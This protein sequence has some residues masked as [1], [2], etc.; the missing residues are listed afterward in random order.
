MITLQDYIGNEI[1]GETLNAIVYRGH[2]RSSDQRVIIK[3][4]KLTHPS[5]AQA[6]R[7]KHEYEIIR[8]VELEGVIKVLDIISTE[9]QLALVMADFGGV[10]LE[11]YF[12]NAMQ[13]APFLD[14][15]I[16]LAQILRS[17]HQKKI[18][19]RDI[20]PANILYNPESDELKLTDFGIAA[21]ASLG[22]EPAV[23]ARLMEGTLAYIS[24]E[25][26]GRMNCTVDYRTDFYSLGVT[27]YELLTGAPPFSSKDPMA[28]IHA[29][30]AKKPEPLHLINPRVPVALSDIIL[31]LMAKSADERYQSGLGL[32]ADLEQCREQLAVQARIDP[33]ELG[34][35]DI[36]PQFNAPRLLVGRAKELNDLYDAFEYVALGGT[37]VLMVSGEPGIGKSSLVNELH[38]TVVAKRGFFLTGKYEQLKQSTPYSGIIQALQGL[39]RQLLAE[40]QERIDLYK[41]DLISILGPN[42]KIITDIIPDMEA[43]L[44]MQPGIAELEPEAAQNRFKRVLRGFV[45][46]FADQG[47][48]LVMFLDDL[49]W[50]DPASPELIQT[51]VFDPE[52]KSFLLIGAYRDNEVSA[53]HPLMFALENIRDHGIASKSIT[54]G[55]LNKTSVNKMLANF[56]RCDPAVSQALATVFQQK[57]LGNPF[58][59]IQFL[60]RLFEGDHLRL[61]PAVGW[62]WE[63]GEVEKMQVTDNV[64]QFMAEK[65]VH[66]PTDAL[67]QIKIGAC[68]GNQFKLETLAAVTEA[69]MDR[70]IET[71]DILVD[72]GLITYNDGVCRFLHDRIQEAAYSLIP[73][74]EREQLHYR[75]GRLA[76]NQTAG[77]IHLYNVFYIAD[78]LN[79]AINILETRQERIQLADINL[80]AG[81]KAKAST[82]Y[83]AATKYLQS[84]IDLL[85]DNAWQSDYELT[86]GL[87]TA[88]MACQYLARNFDESEK[89][90][91]II[92]A[93]ARDRLDK[94]EA[95]NTMI[96]LYTN[97]RPPEEAVALSCSALK[98]FNINLD[99]KMG[100]AKVLPE[101]IKARLKIRKFSMEDIF[102]LPMA[103]DKERSAYHKILFNAGT[104][105]YF[106]NPN[107]F[108][109]IVLK[110]VNEALKYG[111]F[112]HAAVTF[113]T[114]ATLIENILGDYSLGYEMGRMALKLNQ[115]VNNQELSGMVHHIFAFLIQHWNR[116][117]KY[118]LP[119][120]R[121]V[122]QLCLDHGNF[123]Y[124]G[125]S[126]NATADCRLIIGESLESI[127]KDNIRYKGVI[128]Q[129]NDPFIIGRYEENNA[130]IQALKG[131][132]EDPTSLSGPN[133]DAEAHMERQREE[134]NIYGLCFALYHKIKLLYLFGRY[135]Q[136]LETARELERHIKAPLGTLIIS[137]HYYY[138]GLIL[139]ALLHQP[140]TTRR[141]K[142]KRMINRNINKLAKWSALCPENFGHKHDL[143]KAELAAVEG[144]IHQALKYYHGAINGARQNDYVNDEALA[145]ERL[146]CFYLGLSA[147]DEAR[148]FMHRAHQCYGY[149]GATA[150]QQDIKKNHEM[151]LPP[152][153]MG[154]FVDT[155]SQNEGSPT[156]SRQLDLAMVMEA[157]QTISSEIV[158]DQLLQKI[159]KISVTN[160]GAQ[161]GF[162]LLERN[163][164]LIIVAAEETD[165][166]AAPVTVPVPLTESKGLAHAIVYFVNRTLEPVILHNA[167]S[168]GLFTQNPYIQRNLCKSVLCMPILN[169]GQISGLLYMENNLTAN[170]FTDERLEILGVIAAQAA[171]S[172]ENARLFSLATTDG[173]TGLYVHRYFQLLLE[174]E[175][176]R[177]RRYERPF[178]LV[179]MD[180]DN[181]KLFND[182]YGHQQGDEVLKKVA[183]E[184]QD[185]I[186]TV[187]IAARYGGEEFV[188][189]LPE[190]DLTQALVLCEKIRVT[191]EKIPIQ[192]GEK[193]L[194]I[195]ISIG[196][197]TF[198]QHA[199]NKDTL[200][201][202]ADAALYASK[203]NGKNCVSVGKKINA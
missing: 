37:Q 50:C 194:N 193:T 104:P 47:H 136:A 66:L 96:V 80:K 55:P 179:M 132:T 137:E 15:A 149:W 67:S 172:M 3:L 6:A 2:H 191:I 150:K 121:K 176:N 41:Q 65:L 177:S 187:D 1:I 92:T 34:Q 124:A 25:Q 20:K 105:A 40:N 13:I 22:D 154:L 182:T 101:L 75:I 146:A 27:F 164:E 107:L 78:Q 57:T 17:L 63:A 120:Y 180:I 186:R 117:A 51:L 62:Q 71:I 126:V 134:N 140:E 44:G 48:P 199:V 84:G 46:I 175:I 106:L 108:A 100:P 68:I 116:H 9:D 102:E 144:R 188:L 35:H 61:D 59:V 110:G 72:D 99:M 197:A 165:K 109:S 200:I 135:A 142:Y 138:Q 174:K 18:V 181:F 81:I 36:S 76:L 118:D 49:Q 169:K 115:K 30:I 195:T 42:G 56:L 147:R 202:S 93:Q 21:D 123:L 127:L 183:R 45:R 192:P 10:S 24:P 189:V 8:K 5:P 156:I 54:L 173:L 97:T 16:R 143:V 133:F 152:K 170:A 155:V 12:P 196:V 58:F 148:I 103:R 112:P 178:S 198:P 88:Q 113:I 70:M 119:I 131:L 111:L 129:V 125:H 141:G 94:A 167:F 60:K 7:F 4:M 171:I 98:L 184:L 185:S 85:P 23:N 90:F 28:L 14:I 130:L 168:E 73:E 114:F 31:R 151:L 95:Y 86:Y 160:A 128:D 139:A 145:C 69:P 91:K 11:E 32:V 201:E 19:H 53:H 43:I 29:H 83:D 161:R 159:M 82:A 39:A 157:S 64:V 52:L 166:K 26:T 79:H 203:R 33:F 153:T 38:K 77:G 89:L 74:N 158:L 162:L 122:H 163:G 87:Y 190:T